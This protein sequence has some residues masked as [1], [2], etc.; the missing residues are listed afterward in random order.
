M[1]HRQHFEIFIFWC[2]KSFPSVSSYLEESSTALMAQQFYLVLPGYQ[3][4]E[5]VRVC[6]LW[7]I[8]DFWS[9]RIDPVFMFFWFWGNSH[10]YVMFQYVSISLCSVTQGNH[11]KHKLGGRLAQVL[12]CMRGLFEYILIYATYATLYT[13]LSYIVCIST[14]SSKFFSQCVFCFP[15]DSQWHR[16]CN[17]AATCMYIY[18]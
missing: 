3:A 4:E 15:Q 1:F 18:I 5:V 7:K 10:V 11:E 8:V 14:V 17:N 2:F 13:N 12:P 6:W 9:N 16:T